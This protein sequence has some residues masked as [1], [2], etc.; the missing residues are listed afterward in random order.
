MK[1]IYLLLGFLFCVGVYSLADSEK[2][3][4]EGLISDK[5]DVQDFN[6]ILFTGKGNVFVQQG[7]HDVVQIVAPESLIPYIT[8]EVNDGTLRIGEKSMGW[9]LSMKSFKPYEV[10]ITA[11][12]IE[13]ITLAGKGTLT[14][15]ERGIKGKTLTI[16][17]S[18]SGKVDCVVDVENLV[19]H[20]AGTGDYHFKGVAAHQEIQIA[21]KGDYDAWKV[22]GNSA[23][24]DI[25]GVGDVK[26]NVQEKLDISISGKGSVTYMGQPKVTQQIQG[27]GKVEE[28]K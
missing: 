20:T 26:V 3:E 25:R 27:T 9:L 2:K 1:K 23:V 13:E 19:T 5:R 10:Y 17:V 6:K 16:N 4:S 14:S 21:G 11:K 22:R 12:D 7:D 28:L 8:T 18:G 15:A 24:V